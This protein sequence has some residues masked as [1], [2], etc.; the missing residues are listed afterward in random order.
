[1]KRFAQA[2]TFAFA[3]LL[4]VS[5]LLAQSEA[6]QPAAQ[7]IVTV[8]PKNGDNAPALAVSALQVKVDGKVVQP[9]TWHPYGQ[10][11]VQLVL[12]IDNSLRTSFGR[13]LEDLD[14]FV[15]GLPPNVSFGVA[16]MQNGAAMFAGPLSTDHAAAAKLIRLPAGSPGSNASPYFCLQDLAKR[17]PAPPSAARREVIMI[18][19]GVDPYALRYDPDNPYIQTALNAANRAG[20]VV[21]PIYYRD[22]GRLSSTYYETNAGQNYLTQVADATGGNLY[23]EGLSNPVS[24]SPFLTDINRRLENQYELAVP[25]KSAKKASFAELKLKTDNGAVKLKAADRVAVAAE[26]AAAQ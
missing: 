16:Y 13:N 18:T 2:A 21:Y 24:F 7:T 8:L 12:L 23:Y 1:M 20:L 3:A 4:P 10:G 25:V 15:Q 11:E 9:L 19:D 26:G 6:A 5:G 22:Q 14:K 17:W